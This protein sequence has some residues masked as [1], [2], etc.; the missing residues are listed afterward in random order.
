MLSTMTISNSPAPSFLR[1]AAA[2]KVFGRFVAADRL[3]EAR[4]LD[5]DEAVEFFRTLEDLELAA[6]TI[7]NPIAD[8]GSTSIENSSA[9]AELFARDNCEPRGKNAL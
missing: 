7:L 5:D 6:A 3:L 8:T 9:R 2:S 1:C 4:E